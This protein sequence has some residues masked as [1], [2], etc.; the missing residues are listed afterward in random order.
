M[1][2]EYEF[3]GGLVG[4]GPE[5]NAVD[6]TEQSGRGAQANAEGGNGRDREAGSAEQSPE[7]VPKFSRDHADLF[8]EGG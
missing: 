8:S 2:Q 3:L 5:E 6:H 7:S 1:T 4:Q